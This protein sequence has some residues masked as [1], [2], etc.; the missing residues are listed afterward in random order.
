MSGGGRGKYGRGRASSRGILL[1]GL[2]DRR[3]S[4]WVYNQWT[5][6]H[7]WCIN[8]FDGRIAPKTR[9]SAGKMYSTIMS[10]IIVP[11]INLV[12]GYMVR[13]KSN[14]LSRRYVQK[15]FSHYQWPWHLTFQYFTFRV[16]RKH[17]RRTDCWT[18]SP[19]LS[20]LEILLLILSL[21][22]V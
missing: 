2:G 4:P 11:S 16:N 6:P 15:Q 14:H 17:E 3:P 8:Y 12:Y 21:R 13:H 5:L 22:R 1:Q 7:M 9:I 19:I 10:R 18:D 20:A